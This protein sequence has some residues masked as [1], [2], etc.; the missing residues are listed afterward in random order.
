MSVVTLHPPRV[1]ELLH[2]PL[3]A[4]SAGTPRLAWLRLLLT[5]AGVPPA[6]I[7]AGGVHGGEPA[8]YPQAEGAD[9]ADG[10]DAVDRLQL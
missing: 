9:L 1:W 4:V 10:A 8:G 5:S 2:S 3:S 7:F 6:C